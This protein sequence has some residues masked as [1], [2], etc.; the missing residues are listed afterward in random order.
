[1]DALLAAGEDFFC[2]ERALVSRKGSKVII[3]VVVTLLRAFVA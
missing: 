2:F 1:V 3:Y